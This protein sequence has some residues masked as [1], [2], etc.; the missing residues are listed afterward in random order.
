[1]PATFFTRCGFG[2]AFLA[3]VPP[4]EPYDR[5]VV[6]SGGAYGYYVYIGTYPAW[7]RSVHLL[8]GVLRDLAALGLGEVLRL[9]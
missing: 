7:K 2:A 6:S 9:E 4:H 5:G 1:M 8:R 3:P